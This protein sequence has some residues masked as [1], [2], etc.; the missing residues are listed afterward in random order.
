MTEGVE[1]EKVVSEG[2][3]L[4]FGERDY[5]EKQVVDFDEVVVG[6]SPK[7]LDLEWEGY[8][9]PELEKIVGGVE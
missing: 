7:F 1:V 8:V 9:I 5:V 6:S 3:V 4:Y 2:S